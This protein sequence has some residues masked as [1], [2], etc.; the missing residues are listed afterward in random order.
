MVPLF[1]KELKQA[2]TAQTG[3]NF[4]SPY[5]YPPDKY[6]YI[7]QLM[8]KFELCFP[9][10]EEKI[11]VPDLL[12]VGE[13]A[14]DF[15]YAGALKFR[16]CYNFLPRSV[17]PRFMVRSHKD[18]KDKLNWRT[19]VMLEN[20]AFEASAVVKADQEKK[21]INIYVNGTQKRDY[22]AAILH[23]FREINDSFEQIEAKECVPLPD[24]PA[25]SV[26]YLHL[27]RLEKMGQIEFLPDGAE[28]NYNAKELLEGIKPE[29]ERQKEAEQ[30]LREDKIVINVQ[31]PP[32]SKGIWKKILKIAVA[33]AAIIAFIAALFAILDSENFQKFWDKLTGIN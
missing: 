7:F 3:G 22:F 29:K 11:L 33:I 18:I 27:V 8:K 13:P 23:T 15:D 21:T 17:M 25:I 2:N 28:K 30:L 10:D 5:K 20:K 12:D 32:V 19:G 31:P 16:I 9:I 14:I 24:N 4:K 6:K 1:F 26:G